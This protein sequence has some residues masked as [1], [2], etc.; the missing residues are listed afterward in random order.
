MP[1]EHIAK[2]VASAAVRDCGSSMRDLLD[3]IGRTLLVPLRRIAEG[4]PVP[5]RDAL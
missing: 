2:P 4:L 3:S 5:V 1:R